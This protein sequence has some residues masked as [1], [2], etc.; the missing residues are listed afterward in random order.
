MQA[1]FLGMYAY[2]LFYH[3]VINFLY[4]V[5]VVVHL[6][7]LSMWYIS[8]TLK[9]ERYLVWQ[10]SDPSTVEFSK[11][12]GASIPHLVENF[13]GIMVNGKIEGIHVRL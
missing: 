1:M 7:V 2:V 9:L 8:L 12:Q 4:Y 13:P 10:G 11:Y 3:A 6:Q 5:V